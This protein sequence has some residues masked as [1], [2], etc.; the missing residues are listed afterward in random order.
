M[1]DHSRIGR[2][3]SRRGKTLERRVAKLITEWTGETFRRRRVEGR[4]ITTI[5]RD[6]T[7]DVVCANP[8]KKILLSIEVKNAQRFSFD[9]LLANA[10]TAKFTSW[11]HQATLDAQ[12]LT[13]INDYRIYPMLFFKPNRSWDWIAIPT[14]LIDDRLLKP[15]NQSAPKTCWFPSLKYCG[16]SLCGTI[17]KTNSKNAEPVELQLP[18]CYITRWSDFESQVD[19]G[20]IFISDSEK[21]E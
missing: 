10:Q 4:D 19:P 12:I 3:N 15:K 17:S 9:A 1:T 14:E 2:S 20:S 16:Y 21:A 13:N 5:E 7:A 8:H 18:D 11:W 6:S